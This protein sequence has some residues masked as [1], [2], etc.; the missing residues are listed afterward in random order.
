MV[1]AMLDF[2]IQRCTR[3]CAG[4]DKELQPGEPF[5]S[6]LLPEGGEVVRYDYAVDTWQ[7]PPEKAIGWWKSHMPDRN[8]NRL[9]WA[10][11]DV[12][13]HYFVELGNNNEEQD[14]RYVLA[15]LMVRRRILRVEET[16]EDEEGDETM[17][18]Y[19]PR[20]E[21]EYRVA[22]VEPAGDRIR[23]IQDELAALLFAKA[24]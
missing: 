22:V 23:E 19:C 7:G 24:G 3:R 18:L 8:A 4:T 16:E 6:V 12:M 20:N 1:E 10:P 5:F 15:L 2:E 9:H 13:L 14:V 21:T 17:I 11:N